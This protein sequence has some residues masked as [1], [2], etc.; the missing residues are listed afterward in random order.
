MRTII[1]YLLLF[2]CFFIKAQKQFTNNGNFKIHN[3]GTI[4]IYG[5]FINNGSFIDS[6]VVTTLAGTTA[7]QIG[8]STLTTFKNLRLNNSAGS[9]LSSHQNIIGELNI[10]SG[11]FSTSGFDFTL[12]S[13]I[14]GT[15]RIAPI[16][17][18]ITGN[19]TMQRYIGT[20]LT[21]WRF[22]ASPVT[23]VTINDWQDDFITSGFPGSTYPSNPFASV[24]TYDETVGGICD[25]GY[26]AATDA[27]DP[28][29]P[30]IGYWCYIGPV[31]L[32]VDLTGPA[33]KFNHTFPVTYSASAGPLDDGYVM[34]GNPYPCPIDWSSTAWTK[35]NINNAIYIWNPA[36]QQYASWVAGIGTNGGSSAVASSQSF[37]V[38]T[39]AANPVLSCNENVK[40]SSNTPFLKTT[41]PNVIDKIRLS[42]EGNNYKD[43]TYLLFDNMATNGYDIVTDARK[44][45]SSNSDVP[46]ISTLDTTLNDLSINSL[47]PVSSVTHIPVK[48][49]VG[50]SGNYTISIDSSSSMLANFC[51][52]LEDLVTGIKTSLNNS[53]SYTFSISD[54]TQAAR[55]LLHVN[56]TSE[57]NTV[58]VTCHNHQDGKIIAQAKGIGP[59]NYTWYNNANTIIKQTTNT[60][61]PDTLNNL[62][63]GNYLVQTDEVNSS[64]GVFIKNV[65]VTGPAPVYAGF[66]AVKDTVAAGGSDSLIVYNTC[67]G[68]TMFKWN[69]GDGSPVDSSATPMSH[70][71]NTVG[72][73]TLSL[74]AKQNNC[75]DTITKTI[76]VKAAS[77]V[78]IKENQL[79]TAISVY[80]NPGNGIFYVNTGSRKNVNARLIVYT[81]SGVVVLENRLNSQITEVNIQHYAKGLYFYHLAFDDKSTYTGKLIIE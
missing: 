26:N 58:P 42:I 20:G 1:I 31:P 49:L 69:F 43:E 10:S 54:T 36:L 71:Y 25:Y 64:C 3:G 8:G 73:Y 74:V 45:F 46:G 70:H 21:G 15:A 50:T 48:T 56:A 72:E 52:V 17:G 44:L 80:P 34:I 5:D 27:T 66:I 77:V 61:L 33:V 24:Y 59:W 13:D 40:V 2:W 68:A 16:T 39:N 32:T 7:Q 76:F 35:T 37:W 9:Y 18:D 11:T 23:G 29:I 22:L 81:L 57:I 55:F 41:T 60:F 79:S 78:S 65:A 6:G 19:I 51:I 47:P 62:I 63:I 38:Q 4:S 28:I 14:N 67:V 75:S 53:A 30:G 12:I